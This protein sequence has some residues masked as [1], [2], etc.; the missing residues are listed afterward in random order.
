MAMAAVA[1]ATVA[2]D[3]SLKQSIFLFIFSEY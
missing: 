1:E 3:S 2:S